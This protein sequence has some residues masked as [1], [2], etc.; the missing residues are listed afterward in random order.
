MSLLPCT[1]QGS[2]LR[3]FL[4]SNTE[5]DPLRNYLDYCHEKCF[6]LLSEI[7]QVPE[8]VLLVL[9][10]SN[11]AG[12][13]WQHGYLYQSLFENEGLAVHTVHFAKT[14]VNGT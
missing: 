2:E 12:I 5:S 7:V 10:C 8:T 3:L 4:V 9:V 6:E 11:F 14:C 1:C 13:F